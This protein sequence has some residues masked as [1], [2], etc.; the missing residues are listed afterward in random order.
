MFCFVFARLDFALLLRANV[1]FIV[2]AL[3]CMNLISPTGFL[4]SSFID[5]TASVSDV[6]VLMLRYCQLTVMYELL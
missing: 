3:A 5:Y 6:P 2:V 1:G 4:R